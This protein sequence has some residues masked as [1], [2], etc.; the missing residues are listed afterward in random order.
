MEK[1]AGT[2]SSFTTDASYGISVE[3]CR[4]GILV[5]ACTRLCYWGSRS[6]ESFDALSQVIIQLTS[7]ME[8]M[9]FNTDQHTRVSPSTPKKECRKR[10]KM[11]NI[12]A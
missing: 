11:L 4:R 3:D 5:A 7:T 6:A 1:L 8:V 9:T 2:H 10:K 12:R